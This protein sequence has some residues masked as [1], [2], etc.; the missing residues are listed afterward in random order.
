M[1]QLK[2]SNNKP[3][4]PDE[5]CNPNWDG[6]LKIFHAIDPKESGAKE[7]YNALKDLSKIKI[8]TERQH[9]G[10][11]DRCNYQIKQIDNPTPVDSK[12]IEGLGQFQ[13][14]RGGKFSENGKG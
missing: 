7:K 4:P 9:E 1:S 2:F 12:R 14:M 13:K 10:I 6:L 11:I 8:M 3:Y 5:I